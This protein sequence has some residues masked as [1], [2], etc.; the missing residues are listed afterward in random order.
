MAYSPAQEIILIYIY[1]VRFSIHLRIY[2]LKKN[3]ES[4]REGVYQSIKLK[5]EDMFCEG[6]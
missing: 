5:I 6:K 3:N 4:I 1:P 2:I